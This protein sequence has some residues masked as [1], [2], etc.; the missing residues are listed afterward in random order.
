[1]GMRAGDVVMSDQVRPSVPGLRTA[2]VAAA[3]LTLFGGFLAFVLAGETEDWFAWTISP[4]LS[5]AFIGAGY[6]G[7]AVAAFLAS[8]EHHWDRTWIVLPSVTILMSLTLA[9]TF[10]HHDKFDFESFFGWAWLVAYVAFPTV[11]L[12]VAEQQRQA[13]G[14]PSPRQPFPLWM[15]WVLAA[16]AT[17]IVGAAIALFLQPEETAELW[18]WAL[19]P[20]TGRVIGAW[21]AGIGTA[22]AL[23]AW[24][25][26]WRR[27]Y[28]VAVW[29][30]AIGLLQLLAV[31]LH[32][33]DIE[34]GDPYGWVYLAV[35]A[36]VTAVGAAGLAV[37]HLGVTFGQRA[38]KTAASSS[39]TG[40]SS[41]S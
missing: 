24:E 25:G 2:Y 10:M 21:L 41:W 26:C 40:R 16:L 35:V 38:P 1:M 28:P 39:G 12:V 6:W 23:A 22:A 30:C 14:G 29:F 33:D 3:V 36:V 31:A 37:V 9:A 18:P 8:R 11:V 13:T 5:A 4:D 20:L 34:W 32:S 17:V 7:T 19:T 15:T 27:Y